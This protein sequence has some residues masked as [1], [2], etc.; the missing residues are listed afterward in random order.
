VQLLPNIALEAVH[1]TL[2][3]VVHELPLRR[4]EHSLPARTQSNKTTVI[5]AAAHLFPACVPT[6]SVLLICSCIL[7]RVM[8]VCFDFGWWVGSLLVLG[9][10]LGPGELLRTHLADVRHAGIHV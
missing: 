1:S 10:L 6:K 5:W 7:L 8:L 2:R 4:I 9:E 3:Y